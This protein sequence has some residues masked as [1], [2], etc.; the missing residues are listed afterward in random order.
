MNTNFHKKYC[1]ELKL[2][3]ISNLCICDKYVI[4]IGIGVAVR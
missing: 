3:K 4:N 1:L 2:K